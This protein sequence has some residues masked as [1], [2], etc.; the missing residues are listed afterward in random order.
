MSNTDNNS[1]FPASNPFL[2]FMLP[3]WQQGQNQSNT[4]LD[5]DAPARVKV[6]L[7]FLS[8]ISQKTAMRCALNEHNIEWQNGQKLSA[9]EIAAQGAACSLLIEYFSGKMRL[10]DLEI[11]RQRAATRGV[12]PSSRPG[13]PMRCTAC[14]GNGCNIC[15]QRGNVIVYPFGDD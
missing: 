4:L 7:E 3:Y 1:K 14:S 12:I 13:V 5:N 6:A 15:N 8:H 11:A 10:N 9:N 2:P